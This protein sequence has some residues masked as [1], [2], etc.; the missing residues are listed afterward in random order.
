MPVSKSLR[1]V[2]QTLLV[3]ARCIC[4]GFVI[5]TLAHYV[6]LGHYFG[7]N[8]DALKFATEE[9]GWPGAALGLIVAAP[10]YYL[11]LH[12]NASAR[13]WAI[14]AC[15]TLVTATITVSLVS[16]LTIFITPFATLTTAVIMRSR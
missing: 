2:G 11:V 6:G 12:G 1:K 10:I 4:V 13:E 15:V 7:W 8:L 3:A 16:A 5:G 9:G 14:L